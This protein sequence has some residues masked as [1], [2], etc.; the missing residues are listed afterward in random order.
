MNW[1]DKLRWR[2]RN[3]QKF[4]V[5][6]NFCGMSFMSSFDLLQKYWKSKYGSE[7]S[8]YT[9]N[10]VG[11]NWRILRNDKSIWAFI[12][13]I[14]YLVAIQFR[15]SS[16]ASFKAKSH[17]CLFSFFKTI[18][19]IDDSA[20]DRICHAAW[21]SSYQYIEYLDKNGM[22]LYPTEEIVASVKPYVK[23]K[24]IG[25]LCLSNRPF[26]FRIFYPKGS[27]EDKFLLYLDSLDGI[28]RI[29]LDTPSKEIDTII[30][31]KL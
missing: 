17:D 3:K 11:S 23:L 31:T 22:L 15:C 2:L 27:F 5:Q 25:D 10:N 13:R 29:T 20:F 16:Y 19:Y 8:P 18:F 9:A 1:F 24:T 26:I 14:C 4:E 21:K 12:V 30:K 7:E 6:T 28:E